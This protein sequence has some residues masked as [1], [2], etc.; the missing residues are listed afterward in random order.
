MKGWGSTLKLFGELN[1]C[2]YLFYI[3]RNLY[4]LKAFIVLTHLDPR[5]KIT[6]VSQSL[7][8]ILE[9]MSQF[10]DDHTVSVEY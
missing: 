3:S 7:A 1:V 2:S 4:R 8:L 10:V 5:Y 9:F 6:D